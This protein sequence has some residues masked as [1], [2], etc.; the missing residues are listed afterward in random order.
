MNWSLPALIRMDAIAGIAA[1]LILYFGRVVWSPL[2]GLSVE[3]FARLGI[4]GLCYGAFSG[5]ITLLSAYRPV[6]VWTLVTANAL[7]A[8]F[9][10]GL[11][12]NKSSEL[13]ALGIVHLMAETLF[14]GGLAILE[15]R[16][17]PR[18]NILPIHH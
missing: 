6:P 5:S 8:L 14:V 2:S 3:W 9:C 12:L 1:G 18:S 4:V 13:R 16:K 10:L 7:Y 15:S 11:L 17:A